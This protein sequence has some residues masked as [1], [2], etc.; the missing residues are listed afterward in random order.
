MNKIKLPVVKGKKYNHYPRRALCPWCKK[1][2][3]FEP[4]SMAILSGGALLMNRKEKNGGSSDDLD[5]YLSL[6]WH[7][8]HDSGKGD[9]RKIY[10]NIDIASDVKGGEFDLYFCSTKCLRAFLNACVDELEKKI[11]KEKQN[12]TNS[13]T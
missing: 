10:S 8:A 12:L 9:D 2:K 3:V 6:T 13:C 4:H 11:E 5:A 1:K 7:G